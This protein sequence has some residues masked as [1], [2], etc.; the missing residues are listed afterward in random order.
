MCTHEPMKNHGMNKA[1]D[2]WFAF[3][4]MEQT[5]GKLEVNVASSLHTFYVI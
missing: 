4:Q 2:F 5:S 3:W 1:L